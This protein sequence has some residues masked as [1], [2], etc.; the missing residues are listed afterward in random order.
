MSKS[1]ASL[2]E[3]IRMIAQHPAMYAGSPEAAHGMIIAIAAIVLAERGR[4]SIDVGLNRAK[5]IIQEITA[6]VPHANYQGTSLCDISA[7]P[8]HEVSFDALSANA[9]PFLAHLEKL[10]ERC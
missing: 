4:T 8:V 2:L 9:I 10:D 3:F 1:Q 5:E 7:Y 6:S